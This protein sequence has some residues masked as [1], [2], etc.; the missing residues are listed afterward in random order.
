MQ[1]KQGNIYMLV[2]FVGV[3]FLLIFA[4]FLFIVGSAVI[5]WVFDEAVPEVSN[6]GMIGNANMT[7][8]ASYTI[9]PLNNIVQA[10]TWLTGVLYVMLLI[11][12][13]GF[14]FLIRDSPNRWLI[15]FYIGL[16]IMLILGSILISN[17]YEDFSSGDDELA[18]R[19][20]EHTILSFMVLHSPMIFTII[21][22]ISGAIMFSG[23]R[24]EGL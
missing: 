20:R 3:L 1:N 21:S 15:G 24:E 18:T 10:F 13:V 4:G 16:V 22:L 17:I 7:D 19:L 14:A 23:M 12:S 6:L 9:T 2:F 11:A 5:N 8:I